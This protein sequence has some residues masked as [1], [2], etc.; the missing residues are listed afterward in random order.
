MP[1]GSEMAR[2]IVNSSSGYTLGGST[3]S[4]L[5]VWINAFPPVSFDTPIALYEAGGPAPLYTH[6]TALYLERP[7]MQVISRSTSYA[8]ARQNADHV[9]RTLGSISN[10]SVAKTTSTGT[11][12]YA[13]VTPL[14][15]PTDMGTD[16]KGR[17]LI[18]CNYMAEKEMS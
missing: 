13:T 5:P 18:T 1:Y 15:S 3:G 8:T 6:G 9:Y 12:A 14:Q 4:G 16:A 2:Y 11:T 7:S 17:H 10:V